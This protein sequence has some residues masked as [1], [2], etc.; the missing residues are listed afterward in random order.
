MKAC[1]LGS[2]MTQTG[3]R[4]KTAQFAIFPFVILLWAE[5]GK[6][7]KIASAGIMLIHFLMLWKH[8]INLATWNVRTVKR[9]NSERSLKQLLL[10]EVW[11][12]ILRVVKCQNMNVIVVCLSVLIYDLFIVYFTIG[13]S[14]CHTYLS[15]CHIVCLSLCLSVCLS[16]CQLVCLFVCLTVCLLY[17]F[18]GLFVFCC[19]YAFVCLNVC[20]SVLCCTSTS[21]S[22]CWF[23]NL[24]PSAQKPS[25][26]DAFTSHLEN[27]LLKL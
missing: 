7:K 8:D 12:D 3:K 13:L 27:L 21:L 24:L 17:P 25:I 5:I 15:F 23:V 19:E 9:R 11:R 1:W 22:I 18:V 2:S 6:A 10:N 26:L 20:L 14:V 4:K 16:L